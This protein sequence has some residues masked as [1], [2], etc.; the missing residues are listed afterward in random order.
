MPPNAAVTT[1]I[2]VA[3][4][5]V[6]PDSKAIWVP[7]AANNPKPTASGHCMALEVGS[8]CWERKKIGPTM[9]SASTAHTQPSLAT[10]KKGP[11]SS[12]TSRRV[13]PPKAVRNA[14]TATPTTSRRLVAPA[15]TPEAANASTPIPSRISNTRMSV[16]LTGQP[17]SLIR[18][19]LPGCSSGEVIRHQCHKPFGIDSATLGIKNPA[20][21]SKR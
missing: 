14:M 12:N 1:P 9:A 6:A 4:R 20:G 15:S 17:R 7:E 13:P 11:R 16:S 5:G 19:K 21:E 3:T 2:R 10:Q 18:R 8:M